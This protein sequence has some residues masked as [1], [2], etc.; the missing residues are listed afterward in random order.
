[1]FPFQYNDQSRRIITYE[2]L[3]KKIDSLESKISELEKFQ[4]TH[5][6]EPDIDK[7]KEAVRGYLTTTNDIKNLWKGRLSSVDE[8]RVMRRHL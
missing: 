1:M 8:I 7:I 4:L 2:D 6:S 3:V 5:I